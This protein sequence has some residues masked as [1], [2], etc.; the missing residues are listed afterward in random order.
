[1]AHVLVGLSWCGLVWLAGK[2]NFDQVLFWDRIR[3]FGDGK[4]LGP[5]LV[6]CWRVSHVLKWMEGWKWVAS[7]VGSQTWDS[8]QC[9]DLNKPEYHVHMTAD[10]SINATNHA[11]C[12]QTRQICLSRVFYKPTNALLLTLIVA[13]LRFPRM[14]LIVFFVVDDLWI[15][16][17]STRGMEP[18]VLKFQVYLSSHHSP[19]TKQHCIP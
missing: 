16:S 10:N 18:N 12:S 8:A 11:R 17:S 9:V 19:P 1:M 13:M 2:F 5:K 4:L 6:L 3:S 15:F 14:S 7:I